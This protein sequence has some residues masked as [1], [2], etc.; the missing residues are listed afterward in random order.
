MIFFSYIFQCIR[1]G[2]KGIEIYYIENEKKEWGGWAIWSGFY[3]YIRDVFFNLVFLR[4]LY[5]CK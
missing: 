1:K 4:C 5:A 2:I 3:V